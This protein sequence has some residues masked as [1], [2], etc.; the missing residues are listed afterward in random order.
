MHRLTDKQRAWFMAASEDEQA[1]FL[2]RGPAEI[3]AT[4]DFRTG[5]SAY[6]PVIRGLIVGYRSYLDPAQALRVANETL[7]K[8][9]VITHETGITLDEV[10]LG[11]ADPENSP[12]QVTGERS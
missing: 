9:Q 3:C 11:I 10:S 2:A 6:R 8:F 7:E 12:T 4:K 1:A 5:E